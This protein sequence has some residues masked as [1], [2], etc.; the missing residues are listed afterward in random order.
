MDDLDGTGGFDGEADPGF[1]G[2]EVKG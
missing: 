2:R 1:G